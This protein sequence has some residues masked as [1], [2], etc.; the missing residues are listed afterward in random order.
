MKK[1]NPAE[2]SD[3]FKEDSSPFFYLKGKKKGKEEKVS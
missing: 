2:L 3:L 1:D